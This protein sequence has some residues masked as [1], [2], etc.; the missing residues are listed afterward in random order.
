MEV[1]IPSK[2]DFDELNEIAK[3]FVNKNLPALIQQL[4]GELNTEVDYIFDCLEIDLGI[5]D[6]KN[7]K[8]IN[9]KFYEQL[10]REVTYK[11]EAAKVNPSFKFEN[12]ILQFMEQ[13]AF[14]WWMDRTDELSRGL[15]KKKLTQ[16]FLGKV[17]SL[18]LDSKENFFR[19][20]NFILKQDLEN[21][22]KQI[23]K[24]NYSFYNDSIRLL[25]VLS[26]E[27]KHKWVAHNFDKRV[28][29]HFLVIGFLDTKSD[30]K[31]IINGVLNHFAKQTHQELQD[32]FVLS[33]SQIKDEKSEFNQ[34]LT[35]LSKENQKNLA[36]RNLSQQDTRSVLFNYLNNGYEDLPLGFADIAVLQ[37]LLIDVLRRN[38]QLFLKQFKL[39]NLKESS[40][41]IQRLLYLFQRIKVSP[42]K[43]FLTDDEFSKLSEIVSFVKASQMINLLE[44]QKVSAE[45]SNLDNTVLK[46]IIVNDLA[47][48]SDELL[49]NQ[50]LK[51]LASDFSIEYSY[52]IREL[53]L[54]FKSGIQQQNILFSLEKLY[55][56]EVCSKLNDHSL[57][58]LTNVYTN[59]GQDLNLNFFERESFHYFMDLFSTPPLYDFLEKS[60]GTY[61]NL[62]IFISQKI[63]KIESEDFRNLSLKLFTEITQKTGFNYKDWVEN[64]I[65]LIN[66]KTQ[67]DS[68]DHQILAKFTHEQ[69]QEWSIAESKLTS[70]F[71]VVFRYTHEK[72]L[73]SLQEEMIVSLLSLFPQ[74]LKNKSFKIKFS[75]SFDFEK[76]LIDHLNPS[77]ERNLDLLIEN[78]FSQITIFTQ[79][80]YAS[81]VENVLTGLM[82]KSEKTYFD[83]ALIRKYKVSSSTIPFNEKEQA[84]ESDHA[85][86]EKK[87]ISFIH[88]KIILF[89]PNHLEKLMITPSFKVFFSNRK[90]LLDFLAHRF[91]PFSFNYEMHSHLMYQLAIKLKIS[92]N[93]L[94]FEIID[95]I[96][97]K[98]TKT[99]LDYEFNAFFD[100]Y[101]KK[102]RL[103]PTQEKTLN[104]ITQRQSQPLAYSNKKYFQLFFGVFLQFKNMKNYNRAYKNDSNL[105]QFLFDQLTDHQSKNFEEQLSILI[106]SFSDKTN[107][108]PSELYLVSIDKFTSNQKMDEL[109]NRLLSR[110]IFELL[111]ITAPKF[112]FG[113]NA[114]YYNS[115][116]D[117]T[118]RMAS[119]KQF[120]PSQ[121]L[122]I[123][124]YPNVIRSLKSISFQKIIRQLADN[125]D[126]NSK[127]IDSV[128]V[129]GLKSPKAPVVE[130]I[131]YVLLK[132][133]LSTKSIN[134][135]KD[136]LKSLEEHLLRHDPKIIKEGFIN[137]EFKQIISKEEFTKASTIKKIVDLLSHQSEQF[138]SP[139]EESSFEMN[140]FEYLLQYKNDILV[141]KNDENSNRIQKELDNFE[142]II[143]SSDSLLLFLNTYKEDLELLL[144]FTEL[145]LSKDYEK[146]I[147]LRIDQLNKKFLKVEKRLIDLQASYRY[148]TPDKSTLQI[149]LRAILF[150]NIGMTKTTKNF[151]IGEFTYGFFEHLSSER[152]LNL[153]AINKI[154]S[155][156]VSDSIN[157]VI[158]RALS[159]FIDRGIYMGISK[160][161]RDEVYF[162][163]LSLA[164]LKYD[165]LPEW[166]LSKTFTKEDAWSF[167]ISKIENQDFEFTSKFINEL[168]VSHG[169]LEAIKDK[170]IKFFRDLFQQIQS[171]QIGYDLSIKFQ[172]LVNYFSKH[173]W[174]SKDDV[175]LVLSRI[176]LQEEVWRYSGLIKLSQILNEFLKSR[177]DISPTQLSKEI[178]AALGI[179]PKLNVHKPV[180]QFSYEEKIEWIKYFIEAGRFPEDF[181]QD[182]L[183]FKKEFSNL[184]N[185]NTY[186][187]QELWR[188]Y[189]NQPNAVENILKIISEKDLIQRIDEAFFQGSDDHSNM[190]K[191]LFECISKADSLKK[192]LPLFLKIIHE[193]FIKKT[194]NEGLMIPLL[195]ALKKEDESFYAIL[196][197]EILALKKTNQFES[198]S[199]LGNFLLKTDNID[200][201]S[202]VI[203]YE[204]NDLER[205]EYYVEFGST[206]FDEALLSID[207]LYR[208]LQSFLEKDQLL[209]KKRLHQWGNSKNKIR[210]VLKLYPKQNIKS[211]LTLIHP[212]LVSSLKALDSVLI[213][214]Y[215]SSLPLA[216]GLEHWEGVIIYTFGYWSSKSIIL[217]TLKELLQM[218][219]VQILK[220][221][222]MEKEDLALLLKESRFDLPNPIK[223]NLI[224][225]TLKS[226]SSSLTNKIIEP[227]IQEIN[228]LD[229]SESIFIQNAGLV[230]LWPFLSR[231]FDKLNLLD[232]KDF[233]DN[234]SQQKAVL[235]TEY[236][237]TGKTDFQE[238]FLT[239]NKLI[240]G[241]PQDMFVDVNI[242][243]EQFE[244]D[245]CE[246][247]LKSVIKNWEKINN[248]T[249]S[250][251]R[252]TFLIREGVLRTSSIDF[253]LSIQKKPFDVLLSTLPWNISMI[254][255]SFMKNRI[256]VDWI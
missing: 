55:R 98:I 97:I 8:N 45:G 244:L 35:I 104:S 183:Q 76:F 186:K 41:K 59:D 253:N 163:D 14:P 235:L 196:A 67:K 64:V 148:S 179:T 184:L 229:D 197:K 110:L 12:G 7:P 146:T 103:D 22:L 26:Q 88:R 192:S 40:L 123:V 166:A 155:L 165:K 216:L 130:R 200:D 143:S 69:T 188:F 248:S 56:E 120:Y 128:L 84:L 134:S 39:L 221:L 48:L 61:E 212:E 3:S 156:K 215:K 54:S 198:N 214:E 32:L 46:F 124:Y 34:I 36:S 93:R 132:I 225:W 117:L 18:I 47:G 145:G 6:F 168:S 31:E 10:K 13:G 213:E 224:E 141:T 223:Q 217:D 207:D 254:Q 11:I 23:L 135:E 65:Q 238:S 173:S 170:P 44:R 102:A 119:L 125:T 205:L 17:R 178:S 57:N 242:F 181:K 2:N 116:D 227:Q 237:V 209:F 153:R 169:F 83:L 60:I 99:S 96:K 222:S 202:S 161:I 50:F 51:T 234:V 187:V 157:Q 52:L 164:I 95:S 79:F 121:F 66:Q 91:K 27:T 115:I 176:F 162:K 201:L 160:R 255:T 230:L 211:S 68:F 256:L 16:A 80:S 109:S 90:T 43:T 62:R 77:S 241:A 226:E 246:F 105:A 28:L 204:N 70:K 30:K 175:T 139:S 144:S 5:I 228:T 218:F 177:S 58:N 150:K 140:Q 240:C 208:F 20:L 185:E 106:E 111:E 219:I 233:I 81:I 131:R 63:K 142:L 73:S 231:L 113:A 239:L 4:I 1:D 199:S 250:T 78:T 180:D 19:L 114:S 85:Y 33:L 72:E 210:R 53:F 232:D 251:L 154:L 24:T 21:L 74:F 191:F 138:I 87:G 118:I 122:Q 101:D 151:N 190:G 108:S 195:N 94:T 15:P 112:N 158:N 29:Q 37:K 137:T 71:S 49:L 149:L 194:F 38:K 245:L 129:D 220:Q 171:V 25:Q 100:T 159:V 249:I 82:K 147:N 167:V 75:N 107:I 206:K 9:Q 243:L 193:F 203:G 127:W 133:L 247:L 236:L 172:E 174:N 136:F 126:I 92:Y 42:L 182:T 86:L 189:L 89:L 252:E 152:Y